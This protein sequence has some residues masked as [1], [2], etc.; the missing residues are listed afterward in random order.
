MYIP[1]G[2]IWN[3]YCLWC[4]FQA[5][6][7]SDQCDAFG[8]IGTVAFFCIFGS[9]EM[10]K[11]LC[12]FRKQML[13]Q[14]LWDKYNICIPLFPN[15]L[16]PLAARRKRH[17]IRSPLMQP[18]ESKGKSCYKKSYSSISI[19]SDSSRSGLSGWLLQPTDLSNFMFIVIS[20]QD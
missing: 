9:V 7:E 5:K 10:F 6:S 2:S 12:C 14:C 19:Y 15:I 17:C 1:I 20:L 3:L 13:M 18:A 16:L 11:Q 4:W 8:L